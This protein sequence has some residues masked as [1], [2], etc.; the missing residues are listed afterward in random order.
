[1]FIAQMTQSKPPMRASYAKSSMNCQEVNSFTNKEPANRT[2]HSVGCGIDDS[3]YKKGHGKLTAPFIANDKLVY[4]FMAFF[5]ESVPESNVETFRVRKCDIL[6]YKDDNTISIKEKVEQNS[7]I[8]QGQ[9]IKRGKIPKNNDGNYTHE[10]LEVG[11]DIKIYGRVFHIV[12]ADA[13]TRSEKTNMASA[14]DYPSEAHKE[15]RKFQTEMQDPN[16]KKGKRTNPLT[17]YMEASL[18][19]AAPRQRGSGGDGLSVFLKNDGKVL[20]YD[21]LWDDTSRLYGEKHHYRINYFL[22]DDTMEV[23]ETYSSND[24]RDPFPKLLKRARV[25]KGTYLS[26]EMNGVEDITSEEELRRN[27][28]VEQDLVVGNSITVMGKNMLIYACDDATLQW[29]KD[30]EGIDMKPNFIDVSEAPK[31]KVEVAIPPKQGF[32]IGNDEDSLASHLHLIPKCPRKDVKKILNNAGVT[33]RFKANVSSST[34]KNFDDGR[35]FTIKYHV[36]DDTVSIHEHAMRNGGT[37][38]G[39]FLARGRYTD[40]ISGKFFSTQHFA[41]G[42]VVEFPGIT[43]EITEHDEYTR[44]KL[45]ELTTGEGGG[46]TAPTGWVIGQK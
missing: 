44:N 40:G 17:R 3:Q 42:S 26:P 41:E 30:T 13:Y 24:G 34:Q 39:P 35:S 45:M 19:N 2:L 14:E 32:M 23:L 11:T 15:S 8:P 4:R 10:D 38:G 31:S 5:K 29:W 12:D 21:C 43:L 6:Y 33:L 9:F 36:G 22:S 20:H 18:G 7:G 25:P 46:S 37:M 27:F 1:M 28:V 16:K